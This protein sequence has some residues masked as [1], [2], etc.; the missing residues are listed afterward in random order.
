MDRLLDKARQE[1]EST[2]YQELVKQFVKVAMTDVPV[3]PLYQPLLDVT[4][5]NSIDGYVYQFH[6]QVDARTLIRT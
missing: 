5:Q 6:R 4:T 3:I 1:R 2:A